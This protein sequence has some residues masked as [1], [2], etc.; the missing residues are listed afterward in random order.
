MATPAQIK[1]NQSNAQLSSGPRTAEGKAPRFHGA[2]VGTGVIVG[3]VLLDVAYSFESGSYLDS[4]LDT[5]TGI[6]TEQEK[7]RTFHRVYL[8]VIYRHGG[9]P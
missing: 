7:S 4:E 1:A 6:V 5:D 8:S 2:S 9:R 3:P